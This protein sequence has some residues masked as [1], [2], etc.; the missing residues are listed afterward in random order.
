MPKIPT[1]R[2][3]GRATTEVGSVRTNIQAPLNTALADV[4]STIA[5]YYVAEKQEE[6][7]IKSAEYENESWTGL[8]DIIDKHKNNPYPTDAANAYLQDVENYKNNFLNTK[9][10]NANKFT[11]DAFLQKFNSNRDTGLLAVQKGSRI[12][13]DNNKTNQDNMFGSGLATKIRLNPAFA[14]QALI[15]AENYINTNYIDDNEKKIKSQFFS[16]IISATK[17]DMETPEVLL[18]KLKKDPNLYSDVPEEKE[19]AIKNAMNKVAE[20]QE[21][22]FN[23]NISKLVSNTP[24]G[25][26]ADTSA[27]MESQIK[28]LFPNEKDN[29]KAINLANSL[30][31]QKRETIQKEGA[32]QY[33]IDNDPFIKNLYNQSLTDPTRFKTFVQSLDEV[34]VKQKIPKDLRTY[35]PN[36]KIQEIKDIIDG[37]PGSKQRLEVVDSLKSLYGDKMPIINKQIFN[38][39][40]EGVSLAISSNDPDIRSLAI[41]GEVSDDNKR[42]LNARFD[43]QETNIQGKLLKKIES[44]LS[45]LQNVI[46]NQ[47]EGFKRNS[48]YVAK[49]TIGLKDAA[50]NGL[51]DDKYSSTSEAADKISQGYLN[52]YVLTNDTFY[53]PIDVNGK[54]VNQD[55]IEAKAK[56]F[57]TKLY[58]NNIDLE[59]F[60]VT[61]IGE[62]GKPLSKQETIDIFKKNGEWYM[63]GNIGIKYGIK[64]SS[65]KFTPMQINGENVIIDFLDFDSEFKSMKDKF[66]NSYVMGMKDIYNFINAEFEGS[67]S[68]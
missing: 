9:L 38:K 16:K 47:P 25:Q 28:E 61:P 33:F 10:A 22:L 14:S 57:E 42:L 18:A 2:T 67:Q 44:S 50:M 46:L 37:T 58:F 39:V 11:K 49:L 8:Y 20:N 66:G 35:L 3:Q 36:D 54:P 45:P 34:F 6:A 51:L 13:L 19:I 1:Y 63:N 26:Q 4:G 43:P 62:G 17:L 40:G 24:Y 60:D 23:N 32:A 15:E 27:L 31:K 30:F 12:Q 21:N 41:L 64:E 53:I 7:K 59:N 48:S 68:P 65:G 55:F 5:R 29:T 52:D 56:V